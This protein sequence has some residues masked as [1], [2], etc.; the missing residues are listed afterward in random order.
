MLIRWEICDSYGIDT[1]D[2][3]KEPYLAIEI[4]EE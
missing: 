2:F 4:T 1:N 3:P